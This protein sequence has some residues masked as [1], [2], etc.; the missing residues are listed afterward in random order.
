MWEE[1]ILRR[2][3]R[4]VIKG[5]KTTGFQFKITIPYY[6]GLWVS[7]S[8]QGFA[9][10]VD[11]VVYPKDKIS[12]KIGD[13]TYRLADVDLY[14]DNF[15]Y[16]GQPCTVVV[17]KAGG[18]PDGLHKVECGIF[19][20]NSYGTKEPPPPGYDFQWAGGFGLGRAQTTDTRDPM[21]GLRVCAMDLVLVI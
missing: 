12:L 18:L 9:V 5:G 1:F 14:Y 15:W 6:R 2:G 17:E 13:K 20:E 16:Y 19:Y 10:R 7:A 8:F 21:A 4:N 11:G 3:F